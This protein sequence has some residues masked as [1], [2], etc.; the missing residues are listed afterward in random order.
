MGTT[1]KISVQFSIWIPLIFL[2]ITN[3]IILQD[4]EYL[5]N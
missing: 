4:N 2:I 5:M 3:S 1:E